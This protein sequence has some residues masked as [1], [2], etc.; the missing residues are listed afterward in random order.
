MNES[1]RDIISDPVPFDEE[2]ADIPENED[3]AFKA[4]RFNDFSAVERRIHEGF[5]INSRHQ[6]C[7][8]DKI[9]SIKDQT[10]MMPTLR[11]K[12]YSILHVAVIHGSIEMIQLLFTHG[13]DV[14]AVDFNK[15]S[16][17]VIAVAVKRLDV[18][19]LLINNGADVDLQ[20]TSGRTPLKVAIENNHLA[21]VQELIKAGADLDLPDGQGTTPLFMCLKSKNYA[22]KNIVAALIKG[23]CNVNLT[24]KQGATPLMMAAAMGEIEIAKLFLEAGA[25]INKLDASG[26]N[27]LHMTSGIK[28]ALFLINHGATSDYPDKNGQHPIH[29]AVKV[30]HYGR[31]RLLLG[32]DCHRTSSLFDVPAIHEA[33]K[34]FPLFDRWLQQELEEPRELKR[35]CR[36]VIRQCLSPFNTT[37]IDELPIPRLLKDYLL[38][39]HI[40]LS[41]DTVSMN[42]ASSALQKLETNQALVYKYL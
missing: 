14:N 37:R 42:N 4:I 6:E 16:P 35:L 22:D 13:V 29:N 28:M 25:N 34:N 26:K 33:R 12:E 7:P 18:V 1:S 5:N 8:G 31:I 10:K 3:V 32:S 17:L 39:R 15:F 27:A 11:L 30:G 9:F 21:I 23:G 2:C 38:A 41:Y 24:N 20:S 40:D 19:R 36:Q